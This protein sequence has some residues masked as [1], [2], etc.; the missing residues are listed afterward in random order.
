MVDT[1][2]TGTRRKVD[3][4]RPA[5]GEVVEDEGEGGRSDGGARAGDADGIGMLDVATG[6]E[7][8]VIGGAGGLVCSDMRR[9][10]RGGDTLARS[11]GATSAL[12]FPFPLGDIKPLFLLLIEDTGLAE[13][14][15]AEDG[16]SSAR[17]LPLGDVGR[18]GWLTSTAAGDVGFDDLRSDG[19]RL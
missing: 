13:S 18:M 16:M 7:E 17:A 2:R 15:A 4:L 5:R 14:E 1:T 8:R 6:G 11:Q 10:G 19:V 12:P 3:V 9:G